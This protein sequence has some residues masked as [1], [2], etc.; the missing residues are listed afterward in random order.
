[1]QPNQAGYLTWFVAAIVTHTSSIAQ[2]CSAV[3]GLRSTYS[4]VELD[5][6]HF[7]E[8]S[9]EKSSPDVRLQTKVTVIFS[10]KNGSK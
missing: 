1:L 6:R 7:D 8:R 3:A 9:E 10:A 5:L 2:N 4:T